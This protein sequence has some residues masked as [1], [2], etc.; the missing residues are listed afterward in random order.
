MRGSVSCWSTSKRSTVVA[1]CAASACLSAKVSTAGVSALVG[2]TSRG[3]ISS[4]TFLMSISS[5]ER[6]ME[7]APGAGVTETR[8][9][10]GRFM[11]AAACER[12]AAVALTSAKASGTIRTT[13]P[14]PA[15]LSPSRDFKSSVATMCTGSGAEMMSVLDG[16][17]A[18]TSSMDLA[19]TPTGRSPP[20]WASRIRTRS[21]RSRSGARRSARA[22]L[23]VYILSAAGLTRATSSSARSFSTWGYAA[24]GAVTISVRVDLSTSTVTP[25]EPAGAPAEP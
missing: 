4:S 11:E 18:T 17:S 14:L 1:I 16:A 6:M 23:S 22:W 24:A 2:R 3:V 25:R 8:P 20:V 10:L 21:R 7:L 13:L 9:P 5:P 12:A 19:S 15:A